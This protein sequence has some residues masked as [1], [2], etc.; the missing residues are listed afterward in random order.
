MEYLSI[1]RNVAIIYTTFSSLKQF[2]I[3]TT[4]GLMLLSV[5]TA[6]CSLCMM[7]CLTSLT[8]TEYEYS[9]LRR[10]DDVSIRNFLSNILRQLP[11]LGNLRTDYD[12]KW[13]LIPAERKL[14]LHC[15]KKLKARDE[16]CLL[17]QIPVAKS[18]WLIHFVLCS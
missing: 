9:F 11:C 8:K 15:R 3:K 6:V 16:V 18:L 12:K 2:Y 5:E 14:Q 7:N 1:E 17:P 13:C 10:Y 4:E